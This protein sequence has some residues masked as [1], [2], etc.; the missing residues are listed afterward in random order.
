MDNRLGQDSHHND[1]AM[2]LDL[3]VK[4]EV[5]LGRKR[6]P[7]RSLIGLQNGEIVE[8]EGKADQPLQLL[9][10]GALV[11]E[12]EIVIMDDRYG[13]RLTHIVSPS[14]RACSSTSPSD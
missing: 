10:N 3:K 5:L 8:L 9:V 4:A 2:V 12:G 11:A 13:L 7:L 1:I 14:E 6:L